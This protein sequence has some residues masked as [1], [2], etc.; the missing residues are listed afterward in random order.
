VLCSAAVI[1]GITALVWFA[2]VLG[3]AGL[4]VVSLGLLAPLLLPLP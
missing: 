4:G 3:A 2:G 1:T